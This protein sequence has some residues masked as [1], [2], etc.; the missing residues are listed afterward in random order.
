MA[1]TLDDAVTGSTTVLPVN[2]AASTAQ[3]TV[4]DT[5]TTGVAASATTATSVGATQSGDNTTTAAAAQADQSPMTQTAANASS[6]EATSSQDTASAPD[7]QSEAPVLDHVFVGLDGSPIKGLKY[8]FESDGSVID[9]MTDGD[10]VRPP[11]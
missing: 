10:G 8:R 6:N 4:E 5:A 11:R 1:T 9:G 2:A 7:A 3:A